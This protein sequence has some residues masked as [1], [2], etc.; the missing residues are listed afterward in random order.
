MAFGFDLIEW[1]RQQAEEAQKRNPNLAQTAASTPPAP[2]AQQTATGDNQSVL[3]SL[4]GGFGNSAIGQMDTPKPLP[5]P[6]AAPSGQS[7]ASALPTPSSAPD[8]EAMRKAGLNPDD[9]VHRQKFAQMQGGNQLPPVQLPSINLGG[10]AQGVSGRDTD[11]AHT[12][13]L[14]SQIGSTLRGDTDPVHSGALGAQ[15]AQSNKGGILGGIAQGAGILSPTN[16]VNK[17]FWEGGGLLGQLLRPQNAPQQLAQ[18]I[19]QGSQLLAPPNV[20]FNQSPVGGALSTPVQIPNP[21]GAQTPPINALTQP[22][23][24]AVPTPQPASSP[25]ATSPGSTPPT[26]QPAGDPTEEVLLALINGEALGDAQGNIVADFGGLPQGLRVGMAMAILQYAQS[27]MG[28]QSA[29]S[30]AA[31]PNAPATKVG[32]AGAAPGASPAPSPASQLQHNPM[33]DAR[34]Q[35][36]PDLAA[37]FA[38]PQQQAPVQP[39]PPIVPIPLAA[40]RQTTQ[41]MDPQTMAILQSLA[42][43][44]MTPLDEQSIGVMENQLGMPS[45]RMIPINPQTVGAMEQSAQQRLGGAQPTDL[46]SQ[47][48]F[49]NQ[50]PYGGQQL[51]PE[52]MMMLQY[53]MGGQ[54]TPPQGQLPPELAALFAPPQ[55]TPPKKKT[56]TKKKTTTPQE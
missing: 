30:G 11:P 13:A 6:Q 56:P 1:L 7:A 40:P 42:G 19:Q 49:L 31:T 51:D 16:A 4:L 18:G 15:L 34:G 55:Q 12:G 24:Q 20:P 47:W 10:A 32:A 25:T 43:G 54:Q 52:T 17:P 29:P 44:G 41:T 27:E 35:L 22:Q 8:A 46:T 38:P 48:G 39:N 14:P 23:P 9:P 26:A 36:P 2:A 33:M 21:T 28:Q 37:L 5:P 50:P 53:L 3:G 45:N